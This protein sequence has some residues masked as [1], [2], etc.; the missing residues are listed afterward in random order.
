[1]FNSFFFVL[2]DENSEQDVNMLDMCPSTPN[3]PLDFS[4]TSKTIRFSHPKTPEK[5]TISP[6]FKPKTASFF[7]QEPYSFRLEA[8]EIL[9]QPKSEWH[10]RNIRDLANKH[11]PLLSGEGPQR[12][13]I[14]IQVRFFFIDRNDEKYFFSDFQVPSYSIA[15][16]VLSI[17]NVDINGR[18]HRSKMIIPAKTSVNMEKLNHDNNLDC[19]QFDQC[20]SNDRCFAN[21]AHII[22]IITPEEQRAQT[23]E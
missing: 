9:I 5:S 11:I 21:D 12:T 17:R 10:Y 13:P 16:L 18:P 4:R 19:L 20:N 2:A 15:Q 14:R 22:S 3:S 23:K 6:F 7:N 8:P 1:M